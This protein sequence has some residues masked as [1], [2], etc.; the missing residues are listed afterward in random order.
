MRDAYTEF[1]PEHRSAF[2]EST[3]LRKA[4]R[5]PSYHNRNAMS[6]TEIAEA[7][8][9]QAVEQK[10]VKFVDKVVNAWRKIFTG[11]KTFQKV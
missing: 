1:K 7:A 5:V 2:Y 4:H 9:A 10:K 11:R 8:P 3:R 6:Q